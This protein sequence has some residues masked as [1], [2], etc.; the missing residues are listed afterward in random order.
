MLPTSVQQ[1]MVETMWELS[2]PMGIKNL[3]LNFLY[4]GKL[5]DGL[6]FYNVLPRTKADWNTKD[7]NN[8]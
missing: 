7:E 8:N 6:V 3:N 5:G 1:K 4:H 2:V